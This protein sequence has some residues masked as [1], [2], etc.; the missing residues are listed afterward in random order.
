MWPH[1]EQD[2]RHV[3]AVLKL[4]LFVTL[5]GLKTFALHVR[6]AGVLGVCHHTV[7]FTYSAIQQ[8]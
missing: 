5:A 4:G 3:L 6:Y 7:L 8:N 2:A 1:S